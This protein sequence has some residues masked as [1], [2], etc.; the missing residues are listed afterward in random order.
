MKKKQELL[1][2]FFPNAIL[3]RL[4]EKE[5]SCRSFSTQTIP[6]LLQVFLRELQ[7][8]MFA[9]CTFLNTRRHASRME[10]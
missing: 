5:A 9:L 10:M 6:I 3:H 1:K 4:Q 7:Y 8:D 2:R